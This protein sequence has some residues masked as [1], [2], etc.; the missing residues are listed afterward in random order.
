VPEITVDELV[1]E[2]VATDL[3]D[4]KKHALLKQHDYQ[5]AVNLE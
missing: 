1:Q 2:M 5:I 4:A 3:A